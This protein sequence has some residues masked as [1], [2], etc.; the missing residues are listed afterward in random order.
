M[1]NLLYHLSSWVVVLWLLSWVFARA[2]PVLGRLLNQ[3]NAQHA[4]FV[5][6]LYG[7]MAPLAASAAVLIWLWPE[8]GFSIITDHCHGLDCHPHRLQ[9]TLST[10]PAM[11]K[12]C[13]LL[14]VFLGACA[15]MALQWRSG[16]NKLKMLNRLASA[17]EGPYK[18]LDSNQALAW[19]T[20]FLKPQ[21]MVSR[22]LAQ[23]LTKEQMSLVLAHEHAHF[24]RKDNLRK[25]LM[26]WATVAWPKTQRLAIRRALNEY[27]EQACDWLAVQCQP[28]SSQPRS[29]GVQGITAA[30]IETLN[31]C[32]VFSAHCANPEQAAAYE[33][34]VNHLHHLGRAPDSDSHRG[35]KAHWLPMLFTCGLWLIAALVTVHTG[36]PVLEWLA[37]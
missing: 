17:T 37:R 25:G 28:R 12:V 27:T 35:P 32:S 19:S 30:M 1:I 4:A 23:T 36:H 24:Q 10:V 26:H 22:G 13:L 15:T 14:T 8:F 31:K 9:V 6:L 3:A 29:K 11:V 7:L 33:R 5:T 16:R 21:I 34:R 20:G 18:I 2:Y